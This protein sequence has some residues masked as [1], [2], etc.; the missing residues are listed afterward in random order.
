[1]TI[2]WLMVRISGLLLAL[3]VLSHFAYTHIIYDVAQTDAHFVAENLR[4]PL[5]LV[6]DGLML[7]LAMGHAMAGLWIV[8]GEYSPAHCGR[9]RFLLVCAGAL[10]LFLGTFNLCS[11]YL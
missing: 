11:A 5:F 6:W 4:R 3:L 10:M 2:I 1:V 9:W 8:T 7:W